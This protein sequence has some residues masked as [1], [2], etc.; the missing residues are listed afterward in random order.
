M[1]PV[2]VAVGE[3][4]GLLHD[5]E[6]RV[7]GDQVPLPPPPRRHCDHGLPQGSSYCFLFLQSLYLHFYTYNVYT[8]IFKI[9]CVVNIVKYRNIESR[10]VDLTPSDYLHTAKIIN[11]DF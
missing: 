9:K 7:H 4:V 8:D 6:E 3:V 11:H 2:S 10:F 5:G 1:K